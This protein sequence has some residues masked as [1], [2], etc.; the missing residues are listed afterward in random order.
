LITHKDPFDHPQEVADGACALI[1]GL[2]R[3]SV[4]GTASTLADLIESTSDFGLR[5]DNQSGNVSPDQNQLPMQVRLEAL[6]VLGAI[7]D[8]ESMNVILRIATYSRKGE[9]LGLAAQIA[10]AK[11]GT[12]DAGDLFLDMLDPVKADKNAVNNGSLEPQIAKIDPSF[13]SI[14]DIALLGLSKIELNEVQIPRAIKL[15]RTLGEKKTQLANGTDL[16]EQMVLSLLRAGQGAVLKAIAEMIATAPMGQGSEDR[17][18]FYWNRNGSSPDQ[19]FMKMITA[20]SQGVSAK[21][22]AGVAAVI[23]AVVRREEK[24]LLPSETM[25]NWDPKQYLVQFGSNNNMMFGGPMMPM[26]NMMQAAAPA[27][28]SAGKTSPKY[29]PNF[30]FPSMESMQGLMEQNAAM[31][32]IKLMG[33]LEGAQQ[34][35]ESLKKMS[36]YRYMAGFMLWQIGSDAE[37]ETLVSLLAGPSESMKESYLKFLAIDQ[38]ERMGNSNLNAIFAR[39]LSQTTDRAAQAKLGDGALYLSMKTWKDQMMGGTSVLRDS[40]QVDAQVEAW[41][42]KADG[43]GYDRILADRMVITFATLQENDQ[44]LKWM[45]DIVRQQ[46]SRSDPVSETAVGES[47]RI[48]SSLNSGGKD[49]ILEY[50]LTVLNQMIDPEKAR[51]AAEKAQAMP[52]MPPNMG[53]GGDGMMSPNGPGMGAASEFVRLVSR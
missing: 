47:V 13:K 41:R 24:L 32:G 17:E 7:G 34:Y 36:Y 38:L 5:G 53:P 11:R 35:L 52:M 37:G 26:P 25:E 43:R 31:A 12:A 23:T 46:C 22:Q 21:D 28:A 10:L 42:P 16:Q 4:P 48:L 6:S 30:T 29:E 3:W 33:K 1:E 50:Y 19:M 20:L 40:Q 18:P 9:I 14:E 45:T 27:E 15:V 2:G 44:S 51:V 39:A 49:A 8:A